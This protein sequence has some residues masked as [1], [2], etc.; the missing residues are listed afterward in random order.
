MTLRL[1]CRYA[2]AAGALILIAFPAAAQDTLTIPSER[3]AQ[4][5]LSPPVQG[6][7]S[8]RQFQPR[9]NDDNM[10]VIPVIPPSAQVL[11]LPRASTDFIGK[12]GGHLQLAYKTGVVKPPRDA[13]VSLMFGKREGQVVLATTVYGSASSQVLETNAESEGPRAVRIV[14]KGL[15]MSVQPAV[16]HTEKIHLSLESNNLLHCR[17]MVTLYQSGPG[18]IME[19]EYDGDL[20]PL[21]AREDRLLSEEVERAGAVPRARIEEGNPPPP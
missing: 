9:P 17:K 8:Q 6:S 16:Q 7:Q 14:L 2:A 13:I 15:D 4:Q 18:K 10:R 11:V 12:W 19:A 20:R 5:Q 1:R 21:T 3:S